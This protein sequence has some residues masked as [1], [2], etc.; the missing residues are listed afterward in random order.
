MMKC[1]DR[2]S[3]LWADSRAIYG[4]SIPSLM[5]KRYGFEYRMENK[6]KNKMDNTLKDNDRALKFTKAS[7]EAM[8]TTATTLMDKIFVEVYNKYHKRYKKEN[9]TG[10]TMKVDA[11]VYLTV[12]KDLEID[13]CENMWLAAYGNAPLSTITLAEQD[14]LMWEIGNK[15]FWADRLVYNIDE[16][17]Y[18]CK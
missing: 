15:L 9:V 10:E 6:R 13:V 16:G 7:A 5:V 3:Y 14:D 4:N 12:A 8:R 18:S 11:H 1:T 17:T 2:Y